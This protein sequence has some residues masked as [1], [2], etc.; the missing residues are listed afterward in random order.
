MWRVRFRDAGRNRAVT[1]TS[2]KAARRWKGL[3]DATSPKHALAMLDSTPDPAA[4]RTVAEH[5]LAHI[6]AL[7]GVTDGTKR[8]YRATVSRDMDGIGALPISGLSREV[9][10]R[11]INDMSLRGLS[12]KS[13]ANR[14]G[15]L[16][17]AMNRA[18]E[19]HLIAA[20]PCRGIRLPRKDDPDAEM[21]FLSR[22]E[23]AAIHAR[24]PEHYQPLAL[25]L[26]GTGMRFGEATALTVGHVDLA[27]RQARVRQ[28]WKHTG[29]RQLELG[30]PKTPKSR[31]TV[32]LPLPVVE[33]LSPIVADRPRSAWLFTTTR[34]A[35]VKHPTFWKVWT[36]AAS[37]IEPRPRIHD[38]RHTFASWAIQNKIPLPV[39]QRALGHES[40]TT[41]IDTYGHLARADFDALADAT[42]VNLPTARAL[43]AGDERAR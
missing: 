16:S 17:A 6:E 12:G 28:A 32:A 26:V 33:A 27:Q 22:E 31:R 19:S 36:E 4:E 14:H 38:L 34:G 11:W 7:S 29:D 13:I 23:Y 43:A 37:V 18:V 24:M 8:T 3:L 20:N 5:V 30:P 2:E 15:L 41:T 21:I 42:A 39:L 40:I 1:F 25:F 9:V 35:V 10:E